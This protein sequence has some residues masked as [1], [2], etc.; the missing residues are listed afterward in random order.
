MTRNKT[1]VLGSA[2]GRWLAVT[3][4]LCAARPAVGAGTFGN[5]IQL[6]GHI[7]EIVLDEPRGLLYAANFTAG[8]VDVIS[9]TSNQLISSMNLGGQLSGLAM[10][11][12]GRWLVA[13]NYSNFSGVSTLNSMAVVNLNDLTRQN[14]AISNPPLGL[15]FGA[16]GKA[17]VVTTVDLQLFHPAGGTFEP[18]MTIGSMGDSLPVADPRFP[19]EI[20]A[21]SMTASGDG[22]HIFGV[23]N[24]FVF[25]YTVPL[26]AGLN[27]RL[28]STFIHPL[29]PALVT[30]AYDGSY[31]MAGQYLLDRRLRV[32]AEHPNTDTSQINQGGHAI[33]L[34]T[35]YSYFPDL[36]AGGSGSSSGSSALVSGSASQVA[37]LSRLL[38]QDADNLTVRDRIR[39]VERITG[40]MVI[41]GGGRSIYAVSES[42]VIYLPLAEL[43]TL[44]QVR[45]AVEQVFMQFDY[46]QRAPLRQQLQI[47]GAGGADF[48]IISSIP[49]VTFNPS[50][51]TVPATVEVVADFG[52]FSTVQGTTF[53][54]IFIT[55]QNGI[56]V[57]NPIQ[58]SVNVKDADQR[59]RAVPLPGQ[60]V[61]VLADSRREQFYALEQT[62]NELHIFSNSDFRL[63]GTFRT[64]NR[65]SWMTLSADRRYLLIAN[66][67]GENVTVINLDTLQNEGLVFAP[68]GHHPISIAADNATILVASRTTSGARMDWM[69][70]TRRGIFD[71]GP[72]L[73]RPGVYENALSAN[74]AMVP[75]HDM[76]GILIVE[77]SGKVKRW[78]GAGQEVILARQDATGFAGSLAAG[79]TAVVVGTSV[80]NMSLVPQAQLGDAPNQPAG[81]VFFGDEAVRTSTPAAVV[82]TGQVQRFD[83]SRPGIRRSPVRLVEQPATPG[84]FPFLRSLGALR[85]GNFVSTTSSG[86]VELPGSFDAG[87]VI[88]R[89]TAVTAAADFSDRLAAGGLVSIFGENLAP[90][91]RSS[92]VTPLPTSLGQVCVTA[93]AVRLPLLYVSPTQINAQLPF[94]LVGR[95][96]AILHTP[97]G[98]SDTFFAQVRS[99][100]P[101][102]FQL[103][104]AGQSGTFPAIIRGRNNQLA[105]LSNPLR[106]NEFF[107]VFASGLGA[108]TPAVENG[109]A[110]PIAPLATN[111]AFPTVTVGGVPVGVLFSGLAPGFVGL[112]QLNGL[113][114]GDVPLGLQVP[115]T[116]VANGVSTTINVRIVD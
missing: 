20:T 97:G 52:A 108:V 86:L 21:A 88:P 34:R 116:I 42:G 56:N 57:L 92:S 83:A 68:P 112:W 15:A 114:T 40:R 16:D 50:S 1:L 79:P 36:G 93:N 22:N 27:V 103:N 74:T 64:G 14:F 30:A 65:P 113:L 75:L 101:A 37:V 7:S 38:V 84:P 66:S 9:T 12:D 2:L 39:L 58:L 115:M 70:L 10:S 80:L 4:M 61:D 53:G 96:S 25:S 29:A 43:P 59:G 63:M 31:F 78:D 73:G 46:C 87:I 48:E 98:L 90:E 111:R 95:L 44:P 18:V 5:V 28:L 89:I 77:S 55:S 23:T 13:A 94:E 51:G 67:S 100:A 99:A 104:I 91:T 60:I 82:D 76:S 62:K 41:A 49:G 6:D 17:L 85:N 107:T 19:K 26:R 102:V 35:I 11:P 110:A 109:E 8:K 33:G 72:S 81:V 106:P 32:I 24:S 45:P 54:Q 3:A 47:R 71:L 105:T 69:E